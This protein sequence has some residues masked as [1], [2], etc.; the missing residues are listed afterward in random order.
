MYGSTAA[1]SCFRGSKLTRLLEDSLLPADSS[2][3]RSRQCSGVMIVNV[4]PAE[5][6]AKRTLNVLS[7]G[8][9]FS[10]GSKQ[11]VRKTT[12]TTG[13]RKPS[14]PGHPRLLGQGIKD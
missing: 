11:E 13:G 5:R 1:R 14:K 2:S 3:R 9:I 10:E 4:S 6:L 12:K 7:Y 8:Q